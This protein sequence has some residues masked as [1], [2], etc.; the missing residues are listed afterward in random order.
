MSKSKYLDNLIN[1][2]LPSNTRVRYLSEL[3]NINSDNTYNTYRF[4]RLNNF[5]DE[6]LYLIT[7][8]QYLND[9]S[10]INQTVTDGMNSTL[11]STITLNPQ[12][13]PIANV[14]DRSR[15]DLT[16]FNDSIK[17]PPEY[18]PASITAVKGG[19]SS[20]TIPILFP[21]S[22]SRS[23]NATFAKEN[24][25]GSTQAIMAY[26]YTDSEQIPLEFDALADYLPEGYTTLNEYVEEIL[27]I[28]QPRKSNDTIFEPTVIVEF[29]DIRFSGVCT[30]V[31]VSYDNVYNYKSFVHARISCQFTK[32]S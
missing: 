15:F 25:V 20:R 5:T 4:N 32:L 22:F 19:V 9:S 16:K 1:N 17:L 12:F 7:G 24:P 10:N 8:S 23:I 30:S 2:K 29:A 26:S 3:W 21:T 27:N 11:F 14:N 18:L 31:N 13:L 6:E 28:L